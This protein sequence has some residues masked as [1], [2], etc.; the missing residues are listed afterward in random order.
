[1]TGGSTTRTWL[2]VNALQ[3]MRDS[4]KELGVEE[5]PDYDKVELS[6]GA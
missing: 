6:E 5:V 1:M 4:V 2:Y 3:R